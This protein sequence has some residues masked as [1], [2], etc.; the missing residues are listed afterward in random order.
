MRC[1]AITSELEP[2][3]HHVTYDMR[4]IKAP[5]GNA[6]PYCFTVTFKL[7]AKRSTDTQV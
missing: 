6:E 4:A 1:D 7:L 2:R 5:A 3:P